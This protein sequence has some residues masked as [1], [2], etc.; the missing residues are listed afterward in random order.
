MTHE[1]VAHV[2]RRELLPDTVAFSNDN[3]GKAMRVSKW[4]KH[5]KLADGLLANVL[6]THIGACVLRT[7]PVHRL[8]L[9]SPDLNIIVAHWER[10]LG[11]MILVLSPGIEASQ[12]QILVAFLYEEQK[13]RADKRSRSGE[14]FVWLMG[15]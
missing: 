6:E 10:H 13:M 1:L 5:I 8:A 3:G 11:S 2:E 15:M 7:H 14:G 9:Y 12:A 4:L